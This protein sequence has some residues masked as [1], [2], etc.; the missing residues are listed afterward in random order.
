MQGEGET[1]RGRGSRDTK[2]TSTL[3]QR[4]VDKKGGKCEEVEGEVETATF[5]LGRAESDVRG[6]E[7]GGEWYRWQTRF[8]DAIR[9]DMHFDL[10]RGYRG[11]VGLRSAGVEIPVTPVHS[12]LKSLT[13]DTRRAMVN[14]RKRYVQ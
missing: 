13:P 1:E 5:E 2:A 6:G 9:N 8:R 12:R 3:D 7:S 14:Q 10:P 4:R 11:S